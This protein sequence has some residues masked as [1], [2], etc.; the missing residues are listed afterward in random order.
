MARTTKRSGLPI[1][2]IIKSSR[3]TKSRVN[4]NEHSDD[5][6]PRSA[7]SKKRKTTQYTYDTDDDD[8]E[9]VSISSESD[10]TDDDD[11]SASSS[12]DDES[13]APRQRSKK[14]LATLPSRKRAESIRKLTRGPPSKRKL[15][16]ASKRSV[17]R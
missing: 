10:S 12:S 15:A 7:A 13:V 16:A 5:D 9:Q 17:R 6:G 8:D 3:R 1:S 2:N 4:Y 14:L 11:H